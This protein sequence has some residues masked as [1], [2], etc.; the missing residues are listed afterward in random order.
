MT[1][2]A[3]IGLTEATCFQVLGD[4]LTSVLPAG[5]EVDQGQVNRV[6]APA[7]TNYVMMFQLRRTRLG[8]NETAYADNDFT[9][10]IAGTVLTVSA[11]TALTGPGIQPGMQVVDGAYP[12]VVAANTVVLSQTS[13]TPGGIGT[14]EVSPTQTVGSETMY[15]SQRQDLEE[16]EFVVQ[17]DVYGPAAGDNAQLVSTLLR[18]EVATSFFAAANP[19]VSPLHADEPRQ[20]PLIDGERQFEQRYSIEVHL[21]VNPVVGTPQQVFTKATVD[22]VDVQGA[23]PP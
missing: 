10:S 11:V 14:Y 1:V 6:P 20:L 19:A 3:T 9:G 13:G 5:V 15:A 4:F 18:S 2:P 7:G 16:T 17:V 22:L 23:F 12:N 8:T 21:Q